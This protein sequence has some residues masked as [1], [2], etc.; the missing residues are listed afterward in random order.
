MYLDTWSLLPLTWGIDKQ[1][2]N[3]YIYGTSMRKPKKR[4]QITIPVARYKELKDIADYQDTTI[5]KLLISASD[6]ILS[7]QVAGTK[8][9]KAIQKL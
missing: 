1:T 7:R 8:D 5:S 4:I 2:A 3:W 6:T 9:L